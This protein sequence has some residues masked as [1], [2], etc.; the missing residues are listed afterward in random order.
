MATTPNALFSKRLDYFAVNENKITVRE[1]A[2]LELRGYISSAFYKLN[3]KPSDLR[4]IITNILKVP[5]DR[6][7]WSE[8]PNIDYEVDA[9]LKSC[10]WYLVYDVI[11]A[12]IQ[13]L[14]ND[15]Q[16]SF[17]NDMNDFFIGNGIGWKIVN[18]L[19]ERRGDEVYE[20]TIKNVIDDLE[21]AKLHTS[22]TEIKE[23]L[24]CLSRRPIPDLTGAIQHSLACLEC[25]IREY[26]GD[27]KSTLGGIIKKHPGLIPSPLD[28]A[29]S[30]LWGYASERGRHVREGEKLDAIEVELIVGAVAVISTYISKKLVS[31]SK[32]NIIIE[33]IEC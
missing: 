18:G 14:D 27:R 30:N 12:I 5:I 2:P 20:T 32:E 31:N 26:S 6:D 23:A 21:I 22:K 25:A 16:I 13:K 29:I 17:S 28:N 10:N 19:I 4:K 24:F 3:K 9:H 7:N 33:K 8:F 15:N 1:D 11:E